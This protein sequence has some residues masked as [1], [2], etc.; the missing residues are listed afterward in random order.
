MVA[1]GV[2][3]AIGDFDID[4]VPV[5]RCVVTDLRSASVRVAIR[6]C[7]RRA[8]DKIQ[9]RQIVFVGGQQRINFRF[10]CRRE[11]RIGNDTGDLMAFIAPSE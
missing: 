1:G 6:I 2:D 3:I 9:R 5:A 7:P 4:K 10:D 8:T 11:A